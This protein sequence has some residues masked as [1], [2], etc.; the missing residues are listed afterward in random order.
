[1]SERIEVQVIEMSAAGLRISW[2]TN[3]VNSLCVVMLADAYSSSS[4]VR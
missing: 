3:T 4:F 2:T 1:M